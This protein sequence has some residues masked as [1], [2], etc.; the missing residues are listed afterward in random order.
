MQDLHSYI[1]QT[2]AEHKTNLIGPDYGVCS[3]MGDRLIATSIST[4][5]FNVEMEARKEHNDRAE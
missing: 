3:C 2:L 4:H 5:L 1:E